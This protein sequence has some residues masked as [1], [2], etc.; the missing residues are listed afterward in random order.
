METVNRRFFGFQNQLHA[1]SVQSILFPLNSRDIFLGVNVNTNI[2][3]Y[4]NN[5][6]QPVDNR[7]GAATSKTI[8]KYLFGVSKRFEKWSIDGSKRYKHTESWNIGQW[9]RGGRWRL[10]R[11]VENF[12]SFA[13]WM[14]NR[15]TK[16][17]AELIID[18]FDS[19]DK[20][21]S[22]VCP[23]ILMYWIRRWIQLR[24]E[25]IAYENNCWNCCHRI[26]RYVNRFVRKT[27]NCNTQTSTEKMIRVIL[28][29]RRMLTKSNENTNWKFSSDCRLKIF[30]WNSPHSKIPDR[31]KILLWNN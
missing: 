31:I 22:K 18:L 27:R 2:A 7:R 17:F 25:Q 24:N 8:R 16:R 19:I 12:A 13:D 15:M 28:H 29:H 21:K 5:G 4:Q 30:L 23:K 20:Q 10:G 11:F 3:V 1:S 14:L 6:G 9:R 26:V